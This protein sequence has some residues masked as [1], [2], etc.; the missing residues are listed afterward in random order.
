MLITR[1]ARSSIMS[2]SF[3]GSGV[4]IAPLGTESAVF[5]QRFVDALAQHRFIDRPDLDAIVA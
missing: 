2:D 3:R 5:V 1:A 4:I